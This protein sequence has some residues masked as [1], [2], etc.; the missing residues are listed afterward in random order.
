[1]N[2]TDLSKLA[3]NSTLGG[4]SMQEGVREALCQ[5]GGVEMVVEA[6]ELFRNEMETSWINEGGVDDVGRRRKVVNNVINDISRITR[7]SVG[8]SIVCTKRKAPYEYAAVEP[9]PKAAP[10]PAPTSCE[11]WEDDGPLEGVV[12]GTEWLTVRKA[13]K[14]DPASVVMRLFDESDDYDVLGKL[15]LDE[16]K[17]RKGS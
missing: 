17:E 16:L 8:K 14:L 4:A 2:A 1:M 12:N 6:V 7:N 9:K 15:F 3:I 11:P 5:A 13:C 10:A